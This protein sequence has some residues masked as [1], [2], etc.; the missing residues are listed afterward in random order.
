MKQPTDQSP[1]FRGIVFYDDECRICT[2]LLN[3]WGE[4]FRRRGFSFRPLKEGQQQ[5]NLPFPP[6]DFDQEIK[7]KTAEGTWHGGADALLA[8]FRRVWWLAPAGVLGSRPGLRI[9]SRFLYRR[10][11]ANRHCLG[12]SCP[13]KKDPSSPGKENEE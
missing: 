3:R 4:V 11:A 13:V 5:E 12:G 1:S 7:L 2:G 6:E 10:V 8:M 9:L